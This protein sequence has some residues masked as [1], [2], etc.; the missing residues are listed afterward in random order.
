MPG[1]KASKTATS[2]HH[3]RI[4]CLASFKT[5]QLR[6]SSVVFLLTNHFGSTHQGQKT[7][8]Q[9]RAIHSRVLRASSGWHP[10]PFGSRVPGRCVPGTVC[11]ASCQASV[12]FSRELA[13]RSGQVA[14]R[15]APDVPE[16]A[17]NFGP[18]SEIQGTARRLQSFSL[19]A[20]VCTQVVSGTSLMPVTRVRC[21]PEE[22]KLPAFFQALPC[23]A[24]QPLKRTD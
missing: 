16:P 5:N 1:N 17:Q 4:F 21:S 18:G 2:H 10:L 12:F 23:P 15:P 14:S 22:H 7:H 19:P 11:V 9:R 20:K 6:A 24:V 8:G 13:G 3:P